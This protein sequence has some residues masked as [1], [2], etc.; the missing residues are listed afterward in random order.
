VSSIAGGKGTRKGPLFRVMEGEGTGPGKVCTCRE[1][2]WR[3]PWRNAC[4][5]V[6]TLSHFPFLNLSRR[7]CGVLTGS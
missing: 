2:L 7:L 1:E 3:Q 6:L 5:R 4:R